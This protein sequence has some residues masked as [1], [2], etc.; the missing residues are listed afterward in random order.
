MHTRSQS[1]DP[2]APAARRSK[3]V[4]CACTNCQAAKQA[5]DEA[6]TCEFCAKRG[7]ICERVPKPVST[8][9]KTGEEGMGL[10][11]PLYAG[12]SIVPH[13]PAERLSKPSAR[14]KLAA[15]SITIPSCTPRDGKDSAGRDFALGIDGDDDQDMS[16]AST[17]RHASLGVAGMGCATSD[18]MTLLDGYQS[19]SPEDSP[20]LQDDDEMLSTHDS[21]WLSTVDTSVMRAQGHPT[22]GGFFGDSPKAGPLHGTSPG[23]QSS[24]P[25]AAS[26]S[27]IDALMLDDYDEVEDDEVEDDEEE[28]LRE[29]EQLQLIEQETML[30]LEEQQRLNEQSAWQMQQMMAV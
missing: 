21:A 15:P 8:K 29:Q 6:D 27:G 23:M 26:P 19:D 17:L 13:P 16:D 5:C 18:T 22:L 2:N 28:R 24:S 7:L 20:M 3:K 10:A 9:R 11:P 30:R 12:G 1:S 25:S 4:K 14:R